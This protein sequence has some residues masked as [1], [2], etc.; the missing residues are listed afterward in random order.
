MKKSLIINFVFIMAA[1]ISTS[2]NLNAQTAAV[3]WINQ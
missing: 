1:F 3:T 2:T